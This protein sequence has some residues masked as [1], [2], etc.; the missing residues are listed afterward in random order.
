[1]KAETALSV[2]QI[3]YWLDAREIEDRL[4]EGEIDYSV[5]RNV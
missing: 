4:P 1:L 2:Q 3:G 5:A